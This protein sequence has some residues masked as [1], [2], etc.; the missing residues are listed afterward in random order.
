MRWA[1]LQPLKF[2]PETDPLY[3]THHPNWNMP[4]LD[5]VPVGLVFRAARRGAPLPEPVIPIWELPGEADPRV[6]KDYLTENLVGQLHYM[7]GF[8]FEQRDWLRARREF[9]RAVE[10]S[11]HNDVLFYNL[12]L[13]YQRNGLLDDAVDAFERSYAINP[14]HLASQGR[15]RAIDK[16]VELR[17][18]RDRVERLVAGVA[19]SPEMDGLPRRGAAWHER[20]AELLEARGEALAAR[21]Q[22]LQ[23]LQQT[24]SGPLSR[25]GEG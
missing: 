2:D 8:T 12:G 10:L 9:E 4:A 20:V 5:I 18:E 17:A 23:A 6:P 19:A 14:R 25:M 7:L 1:T 24:A 21:G 15:A 22:R 3:F 11:P 16:L 13:I